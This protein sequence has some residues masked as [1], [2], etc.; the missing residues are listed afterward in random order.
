MT[1][2]TKP[3]IKEN[4]Q[5]NKS[6]QANKND[7]LKLNSKMYFSLLAFQLLNLLT[8][9]LQFNLIYLLFAIFVLVLQFIVHF[10]M[11][12]KTTSTKHQPQKYFPLG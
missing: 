5:P 1:K 2:I 4:I 7:D 10:K 9:V 8:L 12:R 6:K 3:R 11:F